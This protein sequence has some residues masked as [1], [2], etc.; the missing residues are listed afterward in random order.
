MSARRYVV[1]L[2][3]LVGL[4]LTLPAGSAA[5][6]PEH[7]FPGIDCK[8][9]PTP[10][11]PG[12]GLAAFFQKRPNPLPP[13]RD[14]F[15]PGAKT[16]IYQQYGFAGLRWHTYDLG[17]GPDAARNPDA[18]IG[19][20]LS[21]WMLNVPISL[22]AATA[23]ITRSKFSTRSHSHRF[24]RADTSGCWLLASGFFSPQ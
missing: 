9:A 23:S 22:T 17:C 24:H 19:T 10:D 5:A 20:A 14:P 7:G 6:Q 12:E 16:T 1:L 18:V 8:G 11:M 2:L 13:Q 3:C 4:L 21:N 15:A